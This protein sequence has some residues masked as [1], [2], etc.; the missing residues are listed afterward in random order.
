MKTTP[1]MFLRQGLITTF[2]ISTLRSARVLN[3]R[4]ASKPLKKVQGVDV[5]LSE[6]A[7]GEMVQ[8][9]AVTSPAALR[10]IVTRCC[11]RSSKYNRFGKHSSYGG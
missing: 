1:C 6:V 2:L 7:L 10:K 11:R 3:R 8:S 9:L 5:R 4:L